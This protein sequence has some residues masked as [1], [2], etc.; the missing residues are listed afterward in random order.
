MKRAFAIAALAVGLFVFSGNSDAATAA[1]YLHSGH[2]AYSGGTHHGGYVRAPVQTHRN[3]GDLFNQGGY[4]HGQTHQPS[5]QPR[6][7]QQY[8]P[9][10][11]SQSYGQHGGLHV[12]IG[13]FHAIGVGRQHH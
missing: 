5:Y 6:Y 10:Y 11:R 13:G 1:D 3:Y 8:A 2:H 9:T 7:Q 12:D 4:G